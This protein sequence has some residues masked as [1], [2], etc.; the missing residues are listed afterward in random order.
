MQQFITTYNKK[1]KLWPAMLSFIDSHEDTMTLINYLDLMLVNFLKTFDLEN[2]III[3][4]LIVVFI[5]ALPFFSM[6]KKNERKQFSTLILL[7]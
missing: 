3:F 1:A 5:V 4:C 2:T 7:E 6:E